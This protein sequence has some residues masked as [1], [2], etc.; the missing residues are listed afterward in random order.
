MVW[1]LLIAAG[2]AAG[3]INSIA[4]GGSFLTF[5]SLVIAGVPAVVANASN[6]VA[7]VPAAVASGFAYRKDIRQLGEGRIRSWFIVSIFG[8][9]LGAILLLYTSDKT[10]R[11]IAPWLLLF[12]T[13]LF[14]FGNQVSVAL[15]G[16]LHANHALM[17]LMLF[18]ISIYGG[19]F[20]GGIGIMILAAFRLYGL[21]DIH[22]MN[23]IKTLLSASLNT[24]AALIFIFAHQ[25]MWR[26]TLIVMAAGIAGGY[27]GPLIARRMKP[28]YIRAL[29]IGVGLVMTGYFFYIAPK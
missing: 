23:G 24:I 9:L 5:P 15:K 25:V 16:R 2:F 11:L 28:A 6:T 3:A 14:A 21:T 19:Y 20:G 4:G 27:V 12:A 29:V 10:F 22:A 17:M 26:P 18:P 1:L 8:G 13:L 7:L